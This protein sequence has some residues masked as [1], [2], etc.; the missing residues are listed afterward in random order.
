MATDEARIDDTALIYHPDRVAEWL[1]RGD[2]YPINVE[3]GINNWCN[4]SCVFCGLDWVPRKE[5][6][7]LSGD[8]LEVTFKDMAAHGVRSVTFSGESE[9]P[10]HPNLVRIVQDG[11]KSGL[12]I[13]LAT[14]GERFDIQRAEQILPYLTWMRFS[15]D[16]ATPETHAKVHRHGRSQDVV[17][18]RVIEN[19]R[20]A[21]DYKRR[22]DLPVTIGTQMV[23]VP[24]N[25]GEVEMLAELM[26]DAGVDN[27]Q[28]KPYS[29]HPC[30]NHPDL[31]VDLSGAGLKE[32]LAKYGK[33]VVYREQAVEHNRGKKYDKCRA[34]PFYCLIDSGGNVMPCNMFYNDP[35]SMYG[36]LHETNGSF[37]AIWES[38]RRREVVDRISSMSLENCRAA[39]VPAA[40]NAYLH[41]LVNPHP[42]DN[43]A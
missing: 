21:A 35:N 34:L 14:N 15:I 20:A 5:R 17:F 40:K 29:H 30:S 24:D 16:A 12:D 36:N 43:F 23:V 4:H 11:K 38:K 25:A 7:F 8:L 1:T 19:I 28:V 13:A 6:R 33:F 9:P 3:I 31:S 26:F 39:C 2:C 42:H 10:L 37:S 41:R 27:F 22:N 18:Q 32:K